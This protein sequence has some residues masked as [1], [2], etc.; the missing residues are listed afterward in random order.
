MFALAANDIEWKSVKYA[1]PVLCHNGTLIAI[2]MAMETTKTKKRRL[3]GEAPPR[4]IRENTSARRAWLAQRLSEIQTDPNIEARIVGK[5]S[6]QE[7][8]K[9]ELSQV[10]ARVR[11]R[12]Y[13]QYCGHEQV[14][15]DGVLVLHGYKRPGDGYIFNECPGMRKPALNVDKS[16]TE[17]WLKEA[18]DV[19]ATARTVLSAAENDKQAAYQAL[20]HGRVDHVQRAIATSSYPKMGNRAWES[21]TSAQRDAFARKLAEWSDIHPEQ[22]AYYTAQD[23]YRAAQQSLWAAES[24]VGNFEYLLANE[25]YGKPLREEYVA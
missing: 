11:L 17:R 4:D 21:P 18:N 16:F 7:I 23:R 9:W 6:Y 12:G 24:L 13:C 22:A 1:V 15:K 3:K 14:V 19:L 2:H 25:Y 10:P 5:G 20:Y 8:A